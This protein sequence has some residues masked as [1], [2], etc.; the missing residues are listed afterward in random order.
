MPFFFNKNVFRGR[1]SLNASACVVIALLIAVGAVSVRA[2]NGDDDPITVDTSLVRLNVGVVDKQGHP[3]ISLSGGDFVVYEDNVKQRIQSFETTT[4]PFSLVMLLDVSGSTKQFRG[5]LQLAALRFL[6]ALAPDDRV[7]IVAFSKKVNWATKFTSDRK[8]LS[9]AIQQADG[10]GDTELYQALQASLEKLKGEGR[11]RKA[12]VVLTDGVDTSV[13][14]VDRR[15]V[16]NPTDTA[17]A[18]AS[19]KPGDSSALQQV[20]NQADRL[21]VTIY[22]LALP[23]GDPRRLA[24]PNAMQ[25]ALYTAARARLQIMADRSGGRLNAIN[26]LEDLGRLY[27]EVAADLRTLYTVT[28]QS[29]N[30]ET[31]RPDKWREIRIELVKPDLLARTRQGY[32]AR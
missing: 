21:G 3:I 15:A 32:F 20:L 5:N 17:E 30:T 19:I 13:R 14:E 7:C 4:A 27:A 24:D 8:V 6:D 31:K 12:I 18:I 1:L 11:R 23:T 25:I 26:R 2:Q 29:S 22:P 16:G 9:Y 28:Y 10:K